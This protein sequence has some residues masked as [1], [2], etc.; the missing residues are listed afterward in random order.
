MSPRC[1]QCGYEPAKGRP[2]KL[3]D[4]AIK[5]LK[6]K[7]KSLADIA[8]KYGVTRGAI[9]AALKRTKK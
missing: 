2:K 5:K 7:G 3:N 8:E 9:Q 6:A 4:A 1:P